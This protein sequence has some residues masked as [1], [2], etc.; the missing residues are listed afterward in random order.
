[1]N[2]KQNLAG[3][4]AALALMGAVVPGASA[5]QGQTGPYYGHGMMG[6]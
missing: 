6:G 4:L 1:M 5:Q 2:T 3:A